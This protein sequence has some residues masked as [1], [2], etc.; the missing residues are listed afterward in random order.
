MGSDH[1]LKSGDR[2]VVT[3]SSFV[4]RTYLTVL[5]KP[6]PGFPKPSEALAEL[7]QEDLKILIADLQRY[8]M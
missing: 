1:H 2:I 6:T 3:D 8:V 5:S 7:D 4:G